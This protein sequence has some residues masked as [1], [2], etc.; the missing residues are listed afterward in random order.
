[1]KNKFNLVV[2]LSF[3]S[4]WIACSSNE[5]SEHKT[6]QDSAYV[7]EG[8]DVS[9]AAQAALL[10]H[11]TQAI[12]TGG[13]EY[14]VQYCNLKASEVMDSISRIHNCTVSRITDRNRNADNA[15]KSDDDKTIWNYFK[16]ENP[17]QSRRDTLLTDQINHTYYRPIKIGMPAC[18]KCHGKPGIDIDSQTLSRIDSLYPDDLAKNY[19]SGDLRG[20]WKIQFHVNQP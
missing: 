15:L 18:L 14:A 19:E 20:L 4:I 12:E 16:N 10:Q 5:T 3:L 2:A 1:M 6:N 9:S 17:A 8:F 11:L 7:Q 13:P